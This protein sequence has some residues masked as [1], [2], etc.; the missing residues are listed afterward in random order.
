MQAHGMIRKYSCRGKVYVHEATRPP[1][2]TESF[3]PSVPHRKTAADLGSFYRP[4]SLGFGVFQGTLK[5]NAAT[6]LTQYYTQCCSGS[7]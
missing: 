3:H 2:N 1:A 4:D 5:L 7:P 6:Y